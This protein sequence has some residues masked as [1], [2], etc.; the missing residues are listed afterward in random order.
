MRH[1]AQ[2]PPRIWRNVLFPLGS[3]RK[4]QVRQLA[5]S[6][7]LRVASK[8]SS[9]GLCFVGKRRFGD[10]IGQYLVDR[11]GEIRCVDDGRVRLALHQGLARC[12][13][14]EPRRCAAR[15]R[16]PGPV[17]LHVGPRGADWGQRAEV[18]RRTQRHGAAHPG[19][20][21]PA[22]RQR[23]LQLTLP[24]AQW[25]A[26]GRCHPAMFS[27]AATTF[28]DITWAS[29]DG[30]PPAVLRATGALRCRYKVRYSQSPLG[31]PNRHPASR[32]PTAA[33]T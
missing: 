3:M 9:T 19:E 10:F 26:P 28:A 20:R 18:F 17:A 11:P 29:P 22:G 32:P 27:G 13:L 12:A 30:R 21:V 31:T 14:S 2:V 33:C 24:R 1:C 25:V 15:W 23:F 4:E 8:K 6:L 16:A 5:E 7:G